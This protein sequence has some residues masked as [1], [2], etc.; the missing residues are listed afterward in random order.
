MSDPLWYRNERDPMYLSHEERLQR[1]QMRAVAWDMFASSILSMSL[2]PG[3]TRDAAQPRS[4][5]ECARMADEM[6]KLR[7]E[8][9]R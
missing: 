5:S 3:T 6:L 8:R 2:H 1:Q 9:F 7:D 4:L